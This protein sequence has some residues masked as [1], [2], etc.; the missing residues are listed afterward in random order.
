MVTPCF[1]S[2]YFSG[3][4]FNQKKNSR[5]FKWVLRSQ[6]TI[7]ICNH[8]KDIA[9]MFLLWYLFMSKRPCSFMIKTTNYVIMLQIAKHFARIFR[10][11]NISQNTVKYTLHHKPCYIIFRS[12]PPEVFLAKAILKIC[13]KLTGE[14]P[15]RSALSIKLH[16]RFV[17][18]MWMT[19]FCCFYC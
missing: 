13:S 19:S 8:M 9:I 5:I 18:L 4:Y 2:G 15:C 1:T 11:R 12:N 6:N 10:M 3:Q 17:K 7:Y 14:H 16:R